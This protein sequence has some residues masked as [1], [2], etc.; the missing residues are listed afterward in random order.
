MKATKEVTKLYWMTGIEKN[1]AIS[2]WTANNTG[3]KRTKD[4]PDKEILGALPNFL[5]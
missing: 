2:K 5:Y 4:N 1:L 3:H